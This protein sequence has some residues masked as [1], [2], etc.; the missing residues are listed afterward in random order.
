MRRLVLTHE[1][2]GLVIF[3]LPQPIKREVRNDITT[4]AWATLLRPVH[5]NEVWIV[6]ASL[7]GKHFP[8]IKSRGI[9]TQVPLSKERGFIPSLLKK[10]RERNLGTIEASPL[11]AQKA[12]HMAMLAR[13]DAGAGRATD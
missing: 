5:L 10:L 4:V 13:E 6:V 12:I 8:S 7:S 11:I 2:E 9:G 1:Q 3:P